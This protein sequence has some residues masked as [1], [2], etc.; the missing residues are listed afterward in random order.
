MHLIRRERGDEVGYTLVELL[1]VVVLLGIVGGIVSTA[2]I[3]GM[4]TTRQAQNRAYS[5]EGIQGQIERMARDIRVADPIR[6]ASGSSLSVD[7]YRT[8]TC[9]RVQWTL[10]AGNLVRTANT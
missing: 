6:S 10:T 3:G 5:T 2:A 1:V 9:V 8:N 7:D 4:R